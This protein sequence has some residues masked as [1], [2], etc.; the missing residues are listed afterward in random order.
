MEQGIE[1]HK[2][3]RRI[4]IASTAMKHTSVNEC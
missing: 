3:I 1:Q 4:Y 2:K